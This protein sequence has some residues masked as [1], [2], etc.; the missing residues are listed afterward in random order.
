MHPHSLNVHGLKRLVEYPG[1]FR[2]L[3]LLVAAFVGALSPND[4]VFAATHHVSIV[5]Y[6]FIPKRVIIAPGDTVVWTANASDHTVNADDDSFDSGSLGPITIPEGTTFSV[7]F[8]SVGTAPYY[9]KLHGSPGGLDM[10]G[11][12]RVVMPG[13]SLPPAMPVNSLPIASA[14]GVSISPLL[15]ASAF[16][17]PDAGDSQAASQWQV[18]QAGTGVL[19]FDS[20]DDSVNK[21]SLR[22]ANLAAETG[23][24]WQV[25]YR[26][27]QGTWS[28]YSSA[29]SFTTASSV[30]LNG[31]GL[32][33]TYARYTLRS[34]L[35]KFVAQRLDPVIDFDWLLAKPHPSAPANN[36]LVRWEGTMLPE[37]SETYRLRIKADGG[38]RLWI[39]GE[40]II[41][42]WLAVAFPLYR[43]GTIALEAG[44]PAT[45]RLDYF[46]TTRHASIKLR[47][48][49]V[50]QLLEVIPQTRL[51]PSN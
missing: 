8:A 34:N 18:R 21:T 7:T 13:S 24:S 33:G 9:C 17:D 28:T 11:T 15:Q 43:S 44:V 46:D 16:S 48:S 6:E 35:E 5:D 19:V 37:Y 40:L 20:G 36:F 39:N 31:V 47:W 26:D 4:E 23:Y 41:E 14:T 10:S 25:R 51:F 3:L 2:K 49:S 38:V 27:D 12:V 22:L 32:L 30:G 45:I 50:S 1:L 29:T 42:D